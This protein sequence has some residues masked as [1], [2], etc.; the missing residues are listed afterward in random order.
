MEKLLKKRSKSAFET[1]TPSENAK[2]ALFIAEEICKAKGLRLTR[3]RYGV[4]QKVWESETPAGA[5][6]ILNALLPDFP[7]AAAVSVYRALDFLTEYGL[8]HRLP[9]QKGF[10]GC[11]FPE[12]EHIPAFL[13]CS[14]CGK[15]EEIKIDKAYKEMKKAAA[16]LKFKTKKA[17]VGLYG[18]CPKCRN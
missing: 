17:A 2:K 6:E 16:S 11:R 4:L 14:V 13:T 12:E 9:D 7:K 18:V 10:I 15:V 1:K 5:Y 8:I 3:L